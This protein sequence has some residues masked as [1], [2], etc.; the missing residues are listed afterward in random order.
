MTAALQENQRAIVVGDQTFGK[1]IVQSLRP[2]SDGENGGV[3]VTIARYETP[4]HHDINKQGIA[5][6]VSIPGTCEKDDVVACIPT[7]AFQKEK[8]LLVSSSSSS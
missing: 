7:E 1:G 8:A 3:A 5:V 6:D 2:L 4:Q